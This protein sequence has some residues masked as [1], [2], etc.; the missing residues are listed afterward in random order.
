MVSTQETTA[1]FFLVLLRMF[2]S[3]M[4]IRVYLHDA[5]RPTP[6]LSFSVGHLYALARIVITASHNPRE[7]NGYK[8][9]DEYGCQLVPSQAEAVTAYVDAVT[10]YKSIHF[11]D[12][13]SLIRLVDVTDD[14]VSE[15]LKQSRY[16][17]ANAKADLRVVYMPL[18]GTGNIPVQ[19]PLRLDGFKQIDT[20]AAQVVP[21]GS[22]PTVVSPNPE[23]RR[24]WEMGIAQVKE[25]DADIVLGTDPDSNRVGIAVKTAD[26]EY[27]LMTGNQVG[28]LLMD[29]IQF[30]QAKIAG[31]SE[32]DYDFLFGYEESYGYLA[33]T[34]ARDKDAVVRCHAYL[35]DG[36]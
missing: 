29:F 10:D 3:D 22:F 5:P 13:P 7:Y 35:R 14:F 36:C 8:V 18:H 19:K 12:N 6:Q 4:G 27:Q 33:G 20:V 9:Y 1:S 32:Q 11:T 17:N 28:T 34:H 30:E 15:V 26:G 24:A 25:T 16:N 23:D 2:L 31:E 21:D